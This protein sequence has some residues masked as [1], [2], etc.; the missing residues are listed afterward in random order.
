MLGEAS[1][2]GS[3]SIYVQDQGKGS[4]DDALLDVTTITALG[5]VSRGRVPHLED[6]CICVRL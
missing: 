5:N 1:F 2:T 6:K 3:M 4:L